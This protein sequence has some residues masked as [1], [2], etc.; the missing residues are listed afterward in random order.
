MSLWEFFGFHPP[1]RRDKTSPFHP[2]TLLTFIRDPLA[3]Y[4][5]FIF[6]PLDG[7]PFVGAIP[8]VVGR[9]LLILGYFSHSRRP[10]SIISSANSAYSAATSTR[11]ILTN[12]N[13]QLEPPTLPFAP[14][15]S[16]RL[17]SPRTESPLLRPTSVHSLSINYLPSKFSDA[18]LYN[19]VKNRGKNFHL[20][21][22]RGG[23][24]EA[25]RS[26]EARMPGEGDEDYDGVQG[27]FFGKEGGR[28]RPRLR[29]NT[30][31]WTLFFSNFLVSIFRPFSYNFPCSPPRRVGQPSYF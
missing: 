23:G 26:G 7:Q 18:V 24:R 9:C 8:F 12:M 14:H 11:H 10:S 17:S 6:S 1:K 29:W 3:R 5:Y 4:F 16:A 28:T 20:G 19:G 31:E 30:F 25:F 13:S 27:S 21:P 22:K 2:G 15:N